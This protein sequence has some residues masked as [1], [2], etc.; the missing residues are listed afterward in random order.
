MATAYTRPLVLRVLLAAQAGVVL[1]IHIWL[2]TSAE[3]GAM[4]LLGSGFVQQSLL[5]NTLLFVGVPVAGVLQT[6]W[7]ASRRRDRLAT[8][9]A[10]EVR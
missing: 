2:L 4:G 9:L 5:V 3:I 10:L 7:Q 8:R 1:W 6:A